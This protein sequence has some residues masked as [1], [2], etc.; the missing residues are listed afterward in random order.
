MFEFNIGMT[1][2]VTA[3]FVALTPGVVVSLP[4]RGSLLQKAVVHGVLFAVIYHLI[5]K[6]VWNFLTEE[7]FQVNANRKATK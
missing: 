5:H 4:S 3:L 7:G 1:L 2:F 6:S